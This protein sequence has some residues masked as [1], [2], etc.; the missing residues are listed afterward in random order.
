MYMFSMTKKIVVR[1]M[2]QSTT[3]IVSYKL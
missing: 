1:Y 2:F 3:G